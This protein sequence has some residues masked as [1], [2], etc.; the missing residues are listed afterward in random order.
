MA[1]YSK[2]QKK[3]IKLALQDILA[4]AGFA[5]SSQLSNFLTFI[6]NKTLDEKELEIKGYT[7]GVDALGRPDDFDPQVDP[8]VRVMAGRL[9]QAL[10]NYIRDTD[11]FTLEGEN[12]KIQLIKGSYI[13]KVELSKTLSDSK[14]SFQDK[15]AVLEDTDINIGFDRHSTQREPSQIKSK[16]VPWILLFACSFGVLITGLIGYNYYSE[17][18]KIEPTVLPGKQ[19]ISLEDA[20]LP[21]LSLRINAQQDDIPE[22]ISAKKIQST[23]V[24]SFSRFN[25]Y[26]VFNISGVE[27]SKFLKRIS[28]D[29]HLSMFFSKAPNNET[30]EA[31][32]NPHSPT[33]Q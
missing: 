1:T 25:E 10:E 32:F 22:W 26:R 6:V 19:I 23:A 11:G 16:T 5:N 29:Y 3:L 20:T 24:V 28:S 4:S 9:R 31:F 18:T 33:N 12:V 15:L 7:I 14:T 21:T 13:P 27:N 30:L 2:A 17:Y 8:S